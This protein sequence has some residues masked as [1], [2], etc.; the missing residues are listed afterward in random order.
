MTQPTSV[1]FHDDRLSFSIHADR[2]SLKVELLDKVSG[3][4]WGPAPLLA[5][6][7][8][9]A[10]LRREDRV[11]QF[12]IESVSPVDQGAHIIVTDAERGVTVGLW[13][14]IQQGEFSVLLSPSE[15]YENRAARFRL[16]TVDLM[17]GMFSVSGP[18]AR[19]LLPVNGASICNPA[20]KPRVSDQWLIYLEQPRWELASMLPV[21]GA[22]DRAGGIAMLA[23]QGAPEAQARV[24]TDGQGAGHIGFA[25]SLRKTWIDPVEAS[26]REFRFAPIPRESDGIHFV[27]KRLRKHLIEDLHKPT[28][29]QRAEESPEVK[30]L[31]SCMTIK[32]FHGMQNNGAAIYDPQGLPP[33]HH[34][35][36]M[37]FCE[38]AGAMRKLRSLG[39]PRLYTQSVGWNARGHDGLY[40]SRF[41][42]ERRSGGEA[43][44]RE[45]FKIGSELGY[46]CNVHDNFQMN[47][48][49]AAD[50]NTECVIHDVYGAPLVR[51]EWAA[52]IEY[53]TWPAAMPAERVTGHLERMKSLGIKGMYYCDYWIAPLEVNYHPRWRGSRSA[54]Q[55][56]MD[57]VLATVKK[58]FGAVG[59]EFG[60]LP[61]VVACDSMAMQLPN[62]FGNAIKQQ[63]NWPVSALVDGPAPVW[64]LACHGLIQHLACGGPSWRNAIDTIAWGASPRDEWGVRPIKMGGIHVFDDRRAV[65]IKAL[66]DL[67]IE[68]FGHLV[69]EEMT[70]CEQGANTV[71]TKFADGTTVE[72]DMSKLELAINGKSLAR[73]AEL[74]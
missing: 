40:P 23:S 58:M 29:R 21:A 35:S 47:T 74:L 71:K 41:P 24:A 31:L 34:V 66:H 57:A 5:F 11:S 52:G 44:F 38:A 64:G 20:G 17:P 69:Y 19:L 16:F 27:A 55:R 26:E 9:D 6:E 12:R 73:P 61:G 70:S 62:W 4:K 14:S 50:W 54:H 67:C 46:Q 30:Y 59:T 53:A 43:A 63:S 51:G 8:H 65:A 48:P 36:T 32:L 22:W 60:T 56:G 45:M 1:S 25:F 7:I 42:V 2:H 15:I 28:L 13:L 10:A 18:D 49:S 3:K 33:T 72:A 37:T 68:K 39:L